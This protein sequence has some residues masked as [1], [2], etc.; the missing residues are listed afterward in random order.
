MMDS[1]VQFFCPR[2]GSEQLPWAVFCEKV[3]RAGYNGTEYA[4]AHDTDAAELDLAWNEAGKNGLVI[5]AQHYDTNK[6][7]FAAHA[8]AYHAWF[9]KARNYPVV[10][11]NSQTGK[12]FFPFYMNTSLISI[13][14]EFSA[15]T[16]TP[17]VHETHRGKFSFAAHVT[18]TFLD[19][20]PDLRIT[21]DVSH[22]CNVSESLLDDQPDALRLAIGRSDHV[23][24]RVGYAE[25]PQVSDP[26]V[27]VWE[28][29][30]YRHL[31][32]W[33]KI[34]ARKKNAGETL[35]IT[36][37]FGPFPYMVH[38]PLINEPIADQWDINVFM[39]DLLRKR[40]Q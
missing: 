7:D 4:I 19:K 37:E 16:G 23:H 29:A 28:E 27:P 11:I 33:D 32:W 17:V 18:K 30:L 6:T 1:P 24:A 10:K 34:A 39:M 26:R 12:D 8:D 3:K 36:P 40:Y 20:I 9:E 15:A 31:H 14:S 13:A 35:T 25:G 5:I 2:W 22:W 38:L 21:F